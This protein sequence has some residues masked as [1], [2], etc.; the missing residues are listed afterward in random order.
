MWFRAG[1]RM[2][3]E[4]FCGGCDLYHAT[5]FVLP[6]TLPNTRRVLTV[7]DLTF[8]RDPASAVPT[9]LTFLKKWCQIRSNGRITSWP[10]R[11]PPPVT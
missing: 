1:L 5:D 3:V 4:V 2:P 6:P 10:I 7:H 8:E 9:L 11:A